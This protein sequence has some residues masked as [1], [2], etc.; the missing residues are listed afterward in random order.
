MATA[1][2]RRVYRKRTRDAEVCVVN[3]RATKRPRYEREEPTPARGAQ[4]DALIRECMEAE[5]SVTLTEY[6]C[7][8]EVISSEGKVSMCPYA[9]PPLR[10]SQLSDMKSQSEESNLTIKKMI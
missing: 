3:P 1:P 10:D 2:S 9:W 6:S 4:L 5:P 7:S 8:R